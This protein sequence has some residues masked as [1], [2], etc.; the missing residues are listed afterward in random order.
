MPDFTALP[1]VANFAIFLAAGVAVW[2]AGTRISRYADAISERSGLSHALLGLLLLGGVTSLPEIGATV[3]AAATANPELAVNNLFGSI[4]MQ[5]AILAIVDFVVGRRAL[6]SIVPDPSVL[7]LCAL[8]VLLLSIAIAGMTTGDVA[9]LGAGVWS[10]ACFAGYIGSVWLLSQTQGRKPWRAALDSG[11]PAQD[12]KGKAKGKGSSGKSKKPTKTLRVLIGQTAAAAAV[13]LSAGFVLAQTGEAIAQQ[14]GLGTSF[15]GFVFLAISTSL[16]EF[17]SALAAARLGFFTMAI[18]DILGTNMINVG[19]LFVV[20]AVAPGE[21]ALNSVD[22]F[23]VLG[24][25][26]SIL[27][28]AIFLVGVVER[29]D[30]TILRMGYDSM[31]V[32]VF[33]AVGLVLLYNMR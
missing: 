5:V 29:R 18:S 26:L 17:S 31:A 24:A 16:P 10:W 14:T 9:F 8:N 12:K 33:Y 22:S 28:T 7:L 1:L 13:I 27:L 23:A 30:R 20:D 3:S 19:L 32:L 11:A 6:T 2:I 15:V 21:P 25:V 4:A